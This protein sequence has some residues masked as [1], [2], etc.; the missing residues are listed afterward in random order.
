MQGRGGV[1]VVEV[2]C[3]EGG[4]GEVEGAVDE[5]RHF[6]FGIGEGEGAGRGSAHYISGGLGGE[7]EALFAEDYPDYL[8]EGGG[9]GVVEKE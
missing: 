6:G 1:G 8:G 9:S 7:F 3:D 4:F 5:G 2:L